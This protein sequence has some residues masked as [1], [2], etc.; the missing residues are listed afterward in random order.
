MND[1]HATVFFR[2]FVADFAAAVGRAVVDNQKLDVFIA[3]REN[4]VKTVAQIFFG[5]VY[6]NRRSKNTDI[7]YLLYVRAAAFRAAFLPAV[8]IFKRAVYGYSADDVLDGYVKP[9]A[10]G[11]VRLKGEINAVVI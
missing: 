4:G 7:I 3:L 5:V 2:I 10:L 1:A 9:A 6:A 8:L 11:V